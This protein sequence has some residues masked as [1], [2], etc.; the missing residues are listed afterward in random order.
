MVT[1]T[2]NHHFLPE[3]VPFLH[4]VVR[5]GLPHCTDA[6]YHRVLFDMARRLWESDRGEDE[7]WHAGKLME[8]VILYSPAHIDE[9]QCWVFLL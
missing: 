1:L 5:F 9:V 3:M 6:T 4:N 7:K 8:L 2:V